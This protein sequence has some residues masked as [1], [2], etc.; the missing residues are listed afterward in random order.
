MSDV[1]SSCLRNLI[2]DIRGALVGIQSIKCT[3]S[4]DSKFCCDLETV[5]QM[6]ATRLSKFS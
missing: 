5:E 3:Y 4:T 2:A 6:V 1:D